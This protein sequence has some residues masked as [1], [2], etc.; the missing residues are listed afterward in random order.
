MNYPGDLLIHVESFLALAAQIDLRRGGAFDRTARDLAIDRSVL[1]RRIQTLSEWLAAPLLDGRA[2]HL[3]LT[4][5]GNRLL[6][7]GGSL[8]RSA[9]DLRATIRSTA[10]R[11]SVACTGTITTELLPTVFVDLERRSPPIR[12]AIRRAGGALAERLVRSA[13]VDLAVIR[14]DAAPKG[15]LTFSL[16]EDRLWLVVKENHP[17]AHKKQ[18]GLE[19]LANDPLVLYGESSR[20]RARV[21]RRLE[22]LGANIHIEVEGRAAAV[23]YV[24]AGAGITFVSLLPGHTV[25]ARGVRARDVTHLFERSR[26]HVIA[27][28]DATHNGLTL[29]VIDHIRRAAL[30]RQKLTSA[31]EAPTDNAGRRRSSVRRAPS[32]R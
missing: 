19:D 25:D 1:R 14:D 15:L 23:A 32:P 16:L 31:S 28:R 17:L 27:R 11:V 18:I 20:T 13:Q 22:P 5:A 29:D 8:V 30:A 3:R 10:E 6:L 24:R 12:L 4:A 2:S 21:M 7:S 9:E 26:F